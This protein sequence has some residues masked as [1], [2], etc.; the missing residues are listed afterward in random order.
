MPRKLFVSLIFLSVHLM[1][2]ILSLDECIDKAIERHPDIRHFIFQIDKSQK[3]VDIA[4]ADYLPQISLNGEYDPLRTY[5]LPANGVFNTKDD[6]G[7]SVGGIVNQKIYDFSKTTLNIDAQK[8]QT[9]IAKLSLK[10]ARAL[11]AYKVR[12][13]YELMLV[14]KKAIEVREKD[15]HSKEELYNQA[16]ALVNQGMKTTADATRFLSS[17]Y[18]A[19]DNYAISKANF[20]KARVTLSLYI[21]EQIKE[22]IDLQDTISDNVMYVDDE[23]KILQKSPTLN[24]LKEDIKRNDLLY[25]SIKASHYGSLDA[26]A[27]YTHQDTLNEYDSTL[28]GVTL[29]I[30]LY[31]GGRTSASAQQ[32]M[33]NK[34]DAKASYDSKA[35]LL[36]EEIQKIYI[37]LDR[38]EKTVAA[39]T[40]QKDAATSTYNLLN[41]R[42]K[43]GLSTYIEVL[44]ALSQKL[45]AELG[46]LSVMYEKSSSINRL[47]YLQGK[48]R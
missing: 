36:K 30:P 46:L 41:A 1:A 22:N 45:D 31:T 38:Y 23:D 2:D 15:M 35:L 18:I 47:K 5:T 3:G 33:I 8:E 34:D 14:Y 26:V 9:A 4:R 44:D 12:L 40:A 20:N 21:D 24:M 19:K 37:D 17:Y 43:E 48:I 27:S 13:Q 29:K 11:L 7:W 28:V 25:R 16:N 39:K 42:Y 32:A 6:D 10:D